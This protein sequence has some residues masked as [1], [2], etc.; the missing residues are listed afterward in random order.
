MPPDMPLAD[1]LLPPSSLWWPLAPGWWLV[2]GIAVLALL[3]VRLRLLSP[4]RRLAL[5]ELR[6][7][8]RQRLQGHELAVAL[9]ALLKRAARARDPQVVNLHG[10][11]W[12]DYLQKGADGFAPE[13][14]RAVYDPAVRFPE[15]EMVRATRRWIGRCL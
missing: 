2:L 1:I 13:M 4:Q 8:R 15:D 7:I 10:Q 9:S 3:L 6:H 11:A 14:L 5:A 12:F